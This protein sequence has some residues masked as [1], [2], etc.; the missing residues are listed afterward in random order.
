MQ[1]PRAGEVQP[2]GLTRRSNPSPSRKIVV[3]STVEALWVT[4]YECAT[5]Y[6]RYERNAQPAMYERSQYPMAGIRANK[7]GGD[8]GR[9]PSQDGAVFYFGCG[10]IRR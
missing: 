10:T 1:A 5:N 6:K 3:A 9:R 4:R 2:L 7:K 8:H